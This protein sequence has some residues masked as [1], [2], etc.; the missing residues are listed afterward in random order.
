MTLSMDEALV[1]VDHLL[2]VDR[3]VDV[4]R[5]GRFTIEVAIEAFDFFDGRITLNNLR[6]KDATRKV[7]TIGYEVYFTLKRGLQLS[8]GLLYFGHML[9]FKSLVDAHVVVAPREVGGSSWLLTC[10]RATCD[11]VYGYIAVDEPHLSGR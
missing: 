7:A 6:G 1:G 9:V 11:G 2:H 4:V 5:E 8:Q 10:A 3:F